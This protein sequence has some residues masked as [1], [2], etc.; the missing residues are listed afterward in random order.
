MGNRF[1]AIDICGGQFFS[2]LYLVA[3]M[4]PSAYPGRRYT[5]TVSAYVAI[6]SRFASAGTAR[7]LPALPVVP[8]GAWSGG[9]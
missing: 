6:L 4:R 7:H 8:L 1:F 2:P 3:L 5:W 9:C